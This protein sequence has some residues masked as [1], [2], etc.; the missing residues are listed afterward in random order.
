M[1]K[2]RKCSTES[3]FASMKTGFATMRNEGQFTC[4]IKS[5]VSSG[6]SAELFGET[7]QS[8]SQR[9]NAPPFDQQTSRVT[10]R[11]TFR[12]DT[13]SITSCGSV[14][15][16]ELKK[17][18]EFVVVTI[19]K[20]IISERS[21]SRRVMLATDQLFHFPGFYVLFMLIVFTV[22]GIKSIEQFGRI[23]TKLYVI[24]KITS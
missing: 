20:L 10:F 8:G 1:S 15:R 19:A 23:S 2:N 12:N 22:R 3:D 9:K 21:F 18:D 11:G 5:A 4:R 6:R 24:R 13:K 7:W 14:G 16:F 17:C